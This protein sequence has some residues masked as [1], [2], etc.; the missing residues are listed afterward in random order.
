MAIKHSFIALVNRKKIWLI[1][2]YVC[3]VG[4]TSIKVTFLCLLKYLCRL[5][6]NFIGSVDKLSKTKVVKANS[7]FLGIQ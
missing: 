6:N 4:P 3:F 7:K 2:E 5:L 1:L